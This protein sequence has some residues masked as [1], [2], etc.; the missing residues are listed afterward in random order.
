MLDRRVNGKRGDCFV[1]GRES[2][3]LERPCLGASVAGRAG[4]TRREEGRSLLIVWPTHFNT[5]HLHALCSPRSISR[6]LFIA[7]FTCLT[8]P[9]RTTPWA[10]NLP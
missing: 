5:S 9:P 6:A 10:L 3:V 8:P 7:P 4:G 2:L 1:G